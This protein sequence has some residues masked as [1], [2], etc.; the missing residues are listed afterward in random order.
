MENIKEISYWTMLK[1]DWRK[2][3]VVVLIV[4]LL[5]LVITLVQPFKYGASVSVLVLQKSSFS[6][7][8][9]SASKSEERIAN[10][11]AN[12][13][14]SSSFME[15][16]MDSRYSIDEDYYPTDELKKRKKWM[17]SIETEVPTGLSKLRIV[18][19]H[20]DQEQALQT[21]RAI[22]EILT[23]EKREY[24]G[25]EDID[26]KVL[27]PPLAS[28]YPL[29]PSVIL[30]IVLSIIIGLISA[31]AYVIIT[32]NPARDRLLNIQSEPEPRLINYSNVPEDESV[33][34]EIEDLKEIPQID[35]LDELEEE[36]EQ[37][38]LQDEAVNRI[39]EDVSVPDLDQE[40]ESA[41]EPQGADQTMNNYTDLPEFNDD[42][43]IVSMK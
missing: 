16:V 28:K 11:L 4:L 2:A 39:E 12:V 27:D 6:I 1:R 21:S 38:E 7:D 41:V 14:Y 10:K 19:Y 24:I 36:A 34:E 13:V 31:F 17:K 43:E 20:P 30:N 5:G 32:Y 25:I 15:K 40:I 18:V 3:I 29:K 26:L 9:Y 35:D 23:Q 8:A 22:A 33:E 42:D 37:E